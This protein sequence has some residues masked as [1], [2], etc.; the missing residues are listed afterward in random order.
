MVKLKRGRELLG[1][2]ISSTSCSGPATED[3][4]DRIETLEE[5][6]IVEEA[7]QAEEEARIHDDIIEEEDEE[8]S[9]EVD[10]EF[11][12]PP[13]PGS[14]RAYPYPYAI[15]VPQVFHVMV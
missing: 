5:E 6:T 4:L 13:S 10:D 8:E 12:V 11:P 14:V 1:E 9:G 3:E 7:E 2:S 15:R